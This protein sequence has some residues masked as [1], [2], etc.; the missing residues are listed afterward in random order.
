[1]KRIL[2]LMVFFFGANLSFSPEI[3]F[4]E[5]G[6]PS[7]YAQYCDEFHG[8]PCADCRFSFFHPCCP[9]WEPWRCAPTK[10]RKKD[11]AAYVEDYTKRRT[12]DLTAIGLAISYVP[13][14]GTAIKQVIGPAALVMGIYSEKSSAVRKDPFRWDFLEFYGGD[15]QQAWDYVAGTGLYYT[16][17]Y[18]TDELVGNVVGLAYYTDY[19]TNEGDRFTSCKQMGL[20]CPDWVAQAHK[21]NVAWGFYMFGWYHGALGDHLWNTAALV[22]QE[23]LEDQALLDYA[24]SVFRD[25]ASVADYAESE[26][27]NDWD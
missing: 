8:I 11:V 27:E 10:Q 3:R 23:G 19:I 1:M 20:D 9:W 7:L 4:V 6:V 17:W 2:F 12:N 24:V 25:I 18:W 16:G 14:G 21:D 5:V 26:Y 22:E 15:W 13:G